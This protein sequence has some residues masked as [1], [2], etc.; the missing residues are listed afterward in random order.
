MQKGRTHPTDIIRLTALI[1]AL[2]ATLAFGLLSAHNTLAAG[3]TRTLNLYYTHTKEAGK[4]TFRKNGQYDQKVLKDLNYFLRDWRRDEVTKMDPA[5]FDL[6]WEVY[7]EVGATKPI[8]V[9]SAYRAPATNNSLRSKSSGVAENSRHTKGMA[10]D[11]YIPGIPVSKLREV[12]MKKQVGGV[13]YYPT[14][15]SPFVHLDTGNVRAWPRMT[16]A[17]LKRL[18]PDGKTL[19][20]PSGSNTP[21]S[22][23]GYQ[24]A[25]AEWNKCHSVPCNTTASAS[26]FAVAEADSG[27][28]AGNGKTL[29]DWLF[30]GDEADEAS[31]DMA[32]PVAAQSPITV[33]SAPATPPEPASR[34]GGF[35]TEQ[36]ALPFGVGSDPLVAEA[37][38]AETPA[39]ESRP[40]W[41]AA[42]PLGDSETITVAAINPAQRRPVATAEPQAL[43][44]EPSAP[45]PFISAYAPTI[46]PEPDAQRAVAMILERQ[47]PSAAN[48]APDLNT[49]SL[50]AGLTDAAP[51][52]GTL[53][54]LLE[55]TMQAII[56]SSE[57]SGADFEMRTP[58]LIAP[59][60]EHVA[61]IFVDPAFL[62][63]SRYAILF[64]HDEADFSPATEL[65]PLAPK[66]TIHSDPSFGLGHTYFSLN[67]PLLVASR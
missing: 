9:V 66:L 61:D 38:L 2:L 8:Y 24:I 19:H 41:L 21:L 10:I 35:Y 42:P 16:T 6:I 59:D 30:G 63:S 27:P 54:A 15:G 49:T 64:D 13:G 40:V 29:M 36:T 32:Q 62:S 39:P 5:L 51:D 3:G 47:D 45:V 46:V 44:P 7:Q 17:Q 57:P 50:K 12:A 14:S 34:P 65:G 53:T 4:F 37:V 60:L 55:G 11:F 33:A 43:P 48:R 25:R 56:P 22:Q 26:T 1:L 28:S 52:P 67:A 18:F 58:T 20:L 23:Q 31:V